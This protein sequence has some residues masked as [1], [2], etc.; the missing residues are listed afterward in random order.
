MRRAVP[1]VLVIVALASAYVASAVVSLTEAVRA[2][3][4][5]D[6]ERL[7]G[8]VDIDSVRGSISSQVVT[9]Y[10]AEIGETRRISQLERT[11][12]MSLGTT[13]ADAVVDKILTPENL[14]VLL[15]SGRVQIDAGTAL[16]GD[17]T[18]L[19]EIGRLNLFDILGRVRL[20]K[21]VE[22]AVRVGKSSDPE[23]SS[24]FHMHFEGNGW[25][26][27]AIEFPKAAL[28]DLA[29]RLPRR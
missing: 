12:A 13:I 22:F 18:P 7:R 11:L 26:L 23:R 16:A 20:I 2:A 9:A 3:Q 4:A 5:G 8:Y 28:R 21:P 29:S 14:A 27:S 25:K 1:A 17:I 10:L 6:G 15:K 24:A 19:A